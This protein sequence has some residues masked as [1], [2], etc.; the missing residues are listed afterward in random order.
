MYSLAN[1]DHGKATKPDHHPYKHD[2]IY[3]IGMRNVF[4]LSIGV[5][6]EAGNFH[7]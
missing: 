4:T 7:S 3:K 6:L 2:T 1:F 5:A